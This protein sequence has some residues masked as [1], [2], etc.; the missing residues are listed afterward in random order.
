MS[1]AAMW[2]DLEVVILSEVNQRQKPCDIY[3]SN[4]KKNNTNEF[5]YKT[6]TD[7]ET[8]KTNSCLQKGTGCVDG[9]IG[10]WDWHMHTIICVMDGQQGPAI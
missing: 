4:L 6:E 7:S 1:F 5:I 10:V 3:S 2:K 8:L 9:C